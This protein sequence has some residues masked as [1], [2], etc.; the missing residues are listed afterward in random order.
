[1]KEMGERIEVRRRDVQERRHSSARLVEGGLGVSERVAALFR[2]AHAEESLGQTSLV[3]F[4]GGGSKPLSEEV[5]L[6]GAAVLVGRETSSGW[7]RNL[8]DL[9]EAQWIPAARLLH[10]PLKDGLGGEEGLPAAARIPGARGGRRSAIRS[11][12]EHG[13][14]GALTNS[15]K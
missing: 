9:A 11:D 15:M 13:D 3:Y 1:M 5:T 7:F 10:V 14:F 12:R 6:V 8:F 4:C 2:V